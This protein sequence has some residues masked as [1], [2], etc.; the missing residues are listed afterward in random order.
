TVSGTASWIVIVGNV[1]NASINPLLPGTLVKVQVGGTI[2]SAG[3]E[4]IRS[5][6][7]TPSYFISDATFAGTIT[8]AAN[9]IFD[10]TVDAHIA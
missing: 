7:G 6:A 2:Q 5:K 4:V 9:H 3:P 10:G 8:P 1:L